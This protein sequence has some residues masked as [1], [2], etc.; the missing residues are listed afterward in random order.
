MHAWQSIL[1]TGLYRLVA[2][3]SPSTSG[4][5]KINNGRRCYV[6]QRQFVV[7]T[8]STYVMHIFVVKKEKEKGY[9]LVKKE[10]RSRL[11]DFDS[12]MHRTKR[13]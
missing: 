8:L 1:E 12:W 7:K 13:Y 6:R 11:N 2:L 4:C 3:M 9:F 10:R 5:I